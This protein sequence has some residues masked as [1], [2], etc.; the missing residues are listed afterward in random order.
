MV[1]RVYI[2][3]SSFEYEEMFRKEGWEIVTSMPKNQE[4][5]KNF[6]V[7]FTGGSDVCPDFYFHDKHPSTWF[8]LRRDEI[9]RDVFISGLN[10]GV[11]F[12]GIC[13]GGQFLHVMNKGKLYQDVSGHA[14]FGTHEVID[15]QTRNIYNATSTHHQMIFP[16]KGVVVAYAKNVSGYKEYWD[17]GSKK[18]IRTIKD[19]TDIECVY[20]SER[21]SL[22]F[23]PHPEFSNALECRK[24]YFKYIND[25][26]FDGGL[27]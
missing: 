14:I 18:I 1:K 15:S 21:R 17:V 25:Y 9:E 19:K 2:I 23:Q 4:E 16:D 10:L 27:P 5:I 6:M 20:H 11:A 22:C 13:R 3:N 8:D 26:L 24:Y 7:Q 12:G